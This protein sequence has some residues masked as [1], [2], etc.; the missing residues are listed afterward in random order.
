MSVNLEEAIP[1][2]LVGALV[3]SMYEQGNEH[4]NMQ[5]VEAE[6]LERIKGL[7]NAT[8]TTSVIPADFYL[9]LSRVTHERFKFLRA[10]FFNLPTPIIVV[11]FNKLWHSY[12]YLKPM[13]VMEAR[14][15]RPVP[16]HPIFGVF[17]PSTEDDPMLLAWNDG[18]DKI[19][20]NK[21][22]MNHIRNVAG[23]AQNLISKDSA[24]KRIKNHNEKTIERLTRENEA[25]KKLLASKP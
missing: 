16:H 21:S 22:R 24:N 20:T 15:Y 11:P 13:S 5:D 6:I 1:M 10:Y 7:A 14:I 4:P 19:S 23:I 12:K 2:T 25:L 9:E 8:S 3:Y 18:Q 17:F